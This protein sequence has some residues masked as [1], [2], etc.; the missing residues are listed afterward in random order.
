MSSR[1]W[2]LHL[3]DEPNDTLLVEQT[4]AVDGL[5]CELVRVDTQSAFVGALQKGGYGLILADYTLPEFDGIAALKIARE[6]CPDVPFIILSGTLGEEPAIDAVKS[7]ATDYVLKQRLSRLGPSVRRALA[8]AEERARRQQ[9]EAALRESEERFRATFEQAAVGI[10]HVA[11]DGRI[12]RA[13]LGFADLVGYSAEELRQRTIQQLTYPE[14]Y[15]QDLEYAHRLLAGDISTYSMEKRYV[16]KNGTLIW[17]NIAVSAV[18]DARGECE[19]L[20]G[21]AKNIAARKEAEEALRQSQAMLA[22]TEQ[23]AN[24]GSCEWDI[25]TGALRWSE[26]TYRLFGTEPGRLV[27]SYDWFIARVHPDDRPRVLAASQSTL[28]GKNPYDVEYRI[29]KPDSTLRWLHAR[30]EVI[31]HESGRPL[32]MIASVLDVTVRKQVE[33][34]LRRSEEKHRLV[35]ENI[36]VAVYSA[37]PDEQFRLTFVSGRIEGLTGYTGAQFAE[38]PGLRMRMIHPEDRERVAQ[39]LNLLWGGEG[40]LRLNYR[41]VR[42]DGA[43]RWLRDCSTAVFAADQHIV[44][45]AGFLEDITDRKEAEAS[46]RVA[47]QRFT[48]MLETVGAI[49]LVLSTDE[50]ITYCNP[51]F[52]ALTGWRK[53]E[54]LGRNWFEM[55]IPPERRAAARATFP[56]APG[57]DTPPGHFDADI[58]TRDGQRQLI[59]WSNTPLCNGAGRMV[60]LAALGYDITDRQRAEAALR[61]ERGKLRGILDAMEDAVCITD[62]RCHITYGNPAFLAQFGPMNGRTCY[63]YFHGRS[64]AC[65]SCRSAEVFAGR[66]VRWEWHSDRTGRTYDAFETLLHQ[67]DGSLAKLQIMHDITARKEAEVALGRRTQELETLMQNAPDVIVRFD[68]QHRYLLVN[69]SWCIVRGCTSEEAL[70]R[71]PREL[72]F[73]PEFC[74]PL[75]RALNQAFATGQL[76]ETEF[77]VQIV[78]G[79]RRFEARIVP[80]LADRPG[81]ETQTA[82]VIARDVTEQRQLEEEL[83][84]SRKM[85]VIGQLAGGIAH[86]INNVLTAISGYAALARVALPAGH[87]VERNLEQ[88]ENAALQAAGIVKGMLTFSHKTPTCRQP[89]N[90]R[91]VVVGAVRFLERL[92][93]ATI[94][95]VVEGTDGPPLWV[96]ADG[97]QLQQVVMNLA[98][99]ARDAMPDGG[100]LR[101][102]L[103]EDEQPAE[104][105]A[106]APRHVARLLVGDTGSG[107]PPDVLPHIFEPFFT[108][109]PPGQGTGLGLAIVQSVAARHGGSIDVHSEAG[110]GTTFAVHLPCIEAPAATDIAEPHAATACGRGELV[111]IV[112]DNVQ[113]LDVI[114]SGLRQMGYQALQATSV[115]TASAQCARFGQRLRLAILDVDLPGGSGLQVL[116]A[117]RS[118]MPALPAVIIT[119]NVDRDLQS[120][121]DERT[122]VFQKPFRLTDLLGAV[123]ELLAQPS[124][125]EAVS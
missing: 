61:Q 108:T 100:T 9:V 105:D 89:L 114:T 71:T 76:L 43:V 79:V 88:V 73:G 65:P 13:N 29:I 121:E 7:G 54:V 35:S 37:L 62:Q 8:E 122:R 27:P 118:S 91:S 30:G 92:L 20:I 103:L 59:S 33:E 36:P 84:Q 119:G 32:R 83:D 81:A 26:Q 102:A 22:R 85:E 70:G 101:I 41:I 52:L 98:I 1:L 2:I 17:V 44:R 90:L 16:R 49:A 53:D 72:G 80:E 6:A 87:I 28:A 45:I 96:S 86:D 56:P 24:V 125:L 68:R 46:Q 14:D 78:S 75:G 15:P 120:E 19:Y 106:T 25:A 123:T 94:E 107:I 104:P 51:Y 64:S 31:R 60:G 109:K 93:P 77:D 55:F 40:P 50:C 4:L 18:R 3:E 97:A 12:L 47:E 99:N 67:E 5:P 69:R 95:V 23:M 117:L 66:S 38:D 113:V 34:E 112:D 42:R 39:D 58:L 124:A 63:E 48:E 10:V 110:K 116:R 115:P 74:D 11:P 82:L 111:L 57:Q 21:I